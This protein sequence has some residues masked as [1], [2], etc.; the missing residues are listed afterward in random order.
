MAMRIRQLIVVFVACCATWTVSAQEPVVID[1]LSAAQLRAEI[2]KV[3]NEFYRVFNASVPGS[4]MTIV[5]HEYLPTGSNIKLEA[6]EPQFVIDRRAG[7]AGD[8]Q[9]NVDELLSPAALQSDLAKEFA[10]LTVAMNKLAG[11]NQYF[12]ELNSVLGMLRERLTEIS[13]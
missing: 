11:E 4:K 13:S 2:K 9:L 3:Q 1:D 10:E 6:C 7:N 12:K 5:C 8:S